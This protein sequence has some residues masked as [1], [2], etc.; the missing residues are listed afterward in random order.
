MSIQTTKFN[1][2]KCTPKANMNCSGLCMLP[3]GAGLLFMGWDGMAP[4]TRNRV[5]RNHHGSDREMITSQTKMKWNMD[6]DTHTV[7][8]KAIQKGSGFNCLCFPTLVFFP[9]D[10]DS[11][12]LLWYYTL[13]L[14]A[15]DYTAILY[16]NPT[17]DV[18]WGAACITDRRIFYVPPNFAVCISL[19]NTDT[20]YVTRSQSWQ[21]TSL[22]QKYI[23][24][25]KKNRSVVA[26]SD[27]S[28]LT[29]SP[30]KHSS[31]FIYK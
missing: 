9:L 13:G 30:C 27:W 21:L 12:I 23:H 18:L 2:H 25:P 31:C 16:R 14:I 3:G 11:L 4:D 22:I 28:Q 1:L 10:I 19:G 26:L 15:F 20:S 8:L 6:T 5:S 24:H 17:C 7:W 29:F